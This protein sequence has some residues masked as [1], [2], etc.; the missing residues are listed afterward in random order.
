MSAPI[1]TLQVVPDIDNES[2]DKKDSSPPCKPAHPHPQLQLQAAKRL[3]EAEIKVSQSQIPPVIVMSPRI[4]L[5][6]RRAHPGLHPPIQQIN[7]DA[8]PLSPAE[9][10][11]HRQIM[12]VQ[13]Q[14]P[15]EP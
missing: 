7:V 11:A 15:S 6:R 12:H 4:S 14:I 13:R 9:I 10:Q 8:Q 2:D 3:V 5:A 1:G